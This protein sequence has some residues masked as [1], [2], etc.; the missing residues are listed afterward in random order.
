MF[1]LTDQNPAGGWTNPSGAQNGDLCAWDT[2]PGAPSA[3]L[4]T[5]TGTSAMQ[6]TWAVSYNITCPDTV[7]FDWAAIILH[8]NSTGR[9]SVLLR[10]TCV[11]HS[12]WRQVNVAVSNGRSY[13]LTMTSRDDGNASDPTYTL[14]DDI[15]VH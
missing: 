4:T 5:A 8:N 6:S 1:Y 10:R 13:T 7:R 14:F 15:S 2:G 9:T 11:A 3:D 12:G